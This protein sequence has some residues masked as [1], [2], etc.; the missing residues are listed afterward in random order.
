MPNVYQASRPDAINQGDIFDAIPFVIPQG[1]DRARVQMPGLVISDDCDADKFLKPRTPLTG[2]EISNFVLTIAPVH[3]IAELTGGRPK[4]VR[5]GKMKRYFLMEEDH[6]HEEL[7]ADLWL[8]QPI[9]VVE[10]L[11]RD[12][13]ACLSGE[14]RRR[15]HV[16]LWELRTRIPAEKAFKKA[17]LTSAA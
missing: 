14:W 2:A 15:L 11:E 8:E 10:I 6:G 17:V 1:A 13:I 7:V 5:D 16:Q 4:A 12:R 3:P 9:P